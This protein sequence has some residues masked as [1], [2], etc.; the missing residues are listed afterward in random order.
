MALAKISLW[1]CTTYLLPQSTASPSFVPNS[2]VHT[3]LLVLLCITTYTASNGTRIIVIIVHCLPD[4]ARVW[5][6]YIR[7]ARTHNILYSRKFWQSL[8]LAVWPQTECKN[9]WWNLN[10]AVAPRS[11]LCHYKYCECGEERVYQGALPSS[12][13][14]YF[15]K[16]VSLQIYKKNITGS[17]LASS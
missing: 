11:I 12:H 2:I 17:M 7:M 1:L 8:N 15:N 13:L 16:A 10:L 9:Y 14:R 3:E 6:L 5:I 4:C